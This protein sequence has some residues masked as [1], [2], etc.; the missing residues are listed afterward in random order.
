MESMVIIIHGVRPQDSALFRIP[1]LAR[2]SIV[3]RN[4]KARTKIA[5]R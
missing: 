5:S 3:T 1:D 2:V 4:M